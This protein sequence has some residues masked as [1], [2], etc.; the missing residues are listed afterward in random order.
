MEQILDQVDSRV[1]YIYGG[2]WERL[3]A[4]FLDGLIVSA[5]QSVL[6]YVIYQESIFSG[7]IDYGFYSYSFLLSL[8]Y[9]VYFISSAKQ[10]TPGKQAM[11]LQVITV[12]G[13]RLSPLNA[14][15]RFL[16]SYLSMIIFCIG[17]LMVAFDSKKQG[18]HDRLADTY[19]IRVR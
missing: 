17:Y 9:H 15:G 12:K 1:E 13:E 14:A 5:A 4:F 11:G 19:V 18:L 3:I 7:T 10:A 6:S 2:F 16:A 8:A